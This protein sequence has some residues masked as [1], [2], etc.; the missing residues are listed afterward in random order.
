MTTGNNEG[1]RRRDKKDARKEVSS[2]EGNGDD[3]MRT[4]A[5][6]RT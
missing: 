5:L 1:R 4:E 3:Y 6:V 2:E